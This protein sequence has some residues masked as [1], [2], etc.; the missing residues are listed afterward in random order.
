MVIETIIIGALPLL[1]GIS[2]ILIIQNTF[3]PDG[4]KSEDDTENNGEENTPGTSL[5]TRTM[6][7][8]GY[9]IAVL[10]IIGGILWI[11][12]LIF[13]PPFSL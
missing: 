6:K 11:L 10:I 8:I 7:I 9:I 12:Y 5:F 3:Q 4:N 1:I 13:W 2:I